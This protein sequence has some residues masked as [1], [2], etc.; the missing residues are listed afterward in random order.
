V[1]YENGRYKFCLVASNQRKASRYVLAWNVMWDL[2]VGHVDSTSSHAEE[3]DT[4]GLW[5]AGA[6]HE[7]AGRCLIYASV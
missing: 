4:K 6:W 2:H 1:P 5:R 7:T 3:D